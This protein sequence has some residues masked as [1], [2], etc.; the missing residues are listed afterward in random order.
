M[1]NGETTHEY[2]GRGSW[3]DVNEIEVYTVDCDPDF[4]VFQASNHF[5]KRY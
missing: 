3:H 5:G 4:F 1:V 2:G